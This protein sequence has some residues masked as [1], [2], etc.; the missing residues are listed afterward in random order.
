MK[1]IECVQYSENWWLARRGIP[2]ASAFD[3]IITSKGALSKACD[4]YIAELIAERVSLNPNFLTE[5]AGHTA[6]MRN[7]INTEP[8][9]RR[10]YEME[11]GVTVQQ[12]GFFTSDDGTFGCSPDGFIPPN[13]L[14]ELKCPRLDTL[15]GWIMKGGI[16]RDH[17]VQTHGELAV[18][19]DNG[20]PIEWLDFMAYSPPVTPLL[21]RLERD[22]FTDKV[23]K[24]VREFNARLQEA[25]EKFCAREGDAVKTPPAVQTKI[26]ES[27]RIWNER[28]A[29]CDSL[30]LGEVCEKVNRL[31]PALRE[32]P[33]V[34]KRPCWEATK[35]RMTDCGCV[36]HAEFKTFA[37]KGAGS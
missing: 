35:L 30:D 24:S 11:R 29:E 18:G 5:R 25:T 36:W 33:E 4:K 19:I 9:A 20:G 12:V 37:P 13:G 16:P 27:L 17:K 23:L 22:E 8:E 14:L 1:H 10:W 32:L 7:G 31:L 34:A 2:T 15:T 26:D 3:R 21:V 28:L 6:E